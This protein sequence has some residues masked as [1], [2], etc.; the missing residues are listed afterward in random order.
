M[1]KNAAVVSLHFSPA[2]VSHMVAF[3]K[4]L[5]ELGF[6]VTFVLDERYFS[7]ADLSGTGRIISSQKYATGASRLKFDTAIFCNAAINNSSVAHEMRTRGTT[8]LYVFHEP[9]PISLHLSEGWKEIFK[10]IVAKYCS[11]AMLR[12]SSGVMVPSACARNLYDKYFAKYNSHVYTLPLLF[13][14]E[15]NTENLTP[16]K[17]KRQYFSFLGNA[18]KAHNFDMF[19]SFAKYAIRT[20]STIKFAIATKTDLNAYFLRDKELLRYAREGRISIQH[21]RAL[22]NKEMNQYCFDSFC[23]WNIYRCST[24]SGVMA[25][26][27]MSGAPVVATQM[28]SFPE[29]VAPGVN[30]EFVDAA[31]DFKGMLHAAEK[32]QR[33]IPTYVEGCHKT[34]FET[35]YYKASREKIAQILHDLEKEKM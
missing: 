15:C 32:I 19:V 26:A 23:V 33:S 14:N 13:D 21:G 30:G 2:Y 25:R 35:F 27:F 12:K 28:G 29:Y 7:F 6:S 3:G 17:N 31:D 8:V 24:Q 20:K 10:L 5:S 9:S 4:L 11:I 18:I 34:F 1:L 16:A 22:S